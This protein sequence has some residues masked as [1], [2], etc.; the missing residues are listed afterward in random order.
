MNL[1]RCSIAA[2]TVMLA[3]TGC[4]TTAPPPALPRPAAA[5]ALRVLDS[6]PV[7]GF[8]N[9]RGGHSWLG[10]PYAAP[11]V[12]AVRWHAPAPVTPWTATRPALAAGAPCIQYGW[13]GGGI[14]AAGTR[15][16]NE[17]CLYL[18]VYGPRMTVAELAASRLPVM[19]W[20]HG[21]SNTV[22]HAAFYDGSTLANAG[23]VIVVMINY[24]LGPFGWFGV[25]GQREAGP[26]TVEGSGNWG[27]LDA[28]AALGAGKRRGL[29]R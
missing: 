7:E 28:L 2:L 1:I 21:G 26:A 27:V 14:G 15:Q 9:D 3:I 4:G 8:V 20:I 18:N 12:G 17:D 22:G 6:G 16:G 25:P 24:R 13:P 10:I 23:R 5:D 11:P 19:V 29:R